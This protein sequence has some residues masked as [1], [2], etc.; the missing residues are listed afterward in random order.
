M[1]EFKSYGITTKFHNKFLVNIEAIAEHLSDKNLLKNT[2]DCVIE[3]RQIRSDLTVNLRYFG[4][5]FREVFG[6]ESTA[7]LK[8]DI[9]H[10]NNVRGN[11]AA[12]IASMT[13]FG[14]HRCFA[15][16]SANDSTDQAVAALDD[17]ARVS[18]T[19]LNTA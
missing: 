10:L 15:E 19:A 8:K 12:G 14:V 17:C 1:A 5:H 6:K 11:T 2:N 9:R 13:A 18:L 16:L 4:H 7:Y 3:K